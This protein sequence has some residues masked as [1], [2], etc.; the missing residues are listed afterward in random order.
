MPFQIYRGLNVQSHTT[1]GGESERLSLPLLIPLMGLALLLA[2]G[3]KPPVVCG[4]TIDQ[5][6]GNVLVVEWEPEQ[7]S[8]WTWHEDI[9]DKMK[10]GSG[11]F[12]H[13]R[14]CQLRRAEEI[15]SIQRRLRD[16]ETS[17][18]AKVLPSQ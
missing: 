12:E 10:E 3:C 13:D 8:A 14:A 4:P 5:R 15:E 16:E 18:M 1:A 7:L 2:A 9:P 6:D 11:L 17:P